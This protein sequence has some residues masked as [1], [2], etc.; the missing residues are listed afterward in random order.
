MSKSVEIIYYRAFAYLDMQMFCPS[1]GRG[2]P[3]TVCLSVCLCVQLSHSSL[4][5]LQKTIDFFNQSV[6]GCCSFLPQLYI[7]YFVLQV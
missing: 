4:L 6:T 5:A 2:V 1:Y 3:L 7:I